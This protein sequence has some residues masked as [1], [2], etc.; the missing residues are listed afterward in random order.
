LRLCIV[1]LVLSA[2]A[3]PA[4]ANAQQ[5]ARAR[6]ISVLSAL[7]P[8]AAAHPI[9]A[10]KQGLRERGYVE[11]QNVILELRYGEARTERLSDLA[12]EQVRAKVDVI[13][14]ATDPGIQAAR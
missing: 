10:F 7:T 3:A 14:T 2:L 8:A 4:A 6:R 9:E 13:V 5:A 12:A 11:G 1:I